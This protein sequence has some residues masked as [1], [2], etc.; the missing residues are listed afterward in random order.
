MP[1]VML[2]ID[3]YHDL[4]QPLRAQAH[5]TVSAGCA[6]SRET[7]G[8]RAALRC[9]CERA[10][11]AIADGGNARMVH[12]LGAATFVGSTGRLVALRP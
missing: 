3:N 8:G 9:A 12:G 4:P 7:Y 2:D 6:W 11:V 10:A 5:R 1:T